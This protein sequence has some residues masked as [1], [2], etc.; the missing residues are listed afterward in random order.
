MG[1]MGKHSKGEDKMKKSN[2]DLFV[3]TPSKY[4]E[5]K[6]KEVAPKNYIT[7]DRSFFELPIKEKVN[8]L[9]LLVRF[10]K[11]EILLM[12]KEKNILK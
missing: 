11:G 10:I 3:N 6:F 9:K 4:R 1:R 7:I 2:N 12:K 8:C 5:I